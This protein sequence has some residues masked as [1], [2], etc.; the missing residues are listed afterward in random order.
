MMKVEILGC[1]GGP[2]VGAR[3]S[4]YLV[5]DHLLIDA[6]H[7]VSALDQERLDRIDCVI[8]THC[9]FDHILE[10][11]FLPMTRD[12]E[13]T[14]PLLLVGA[15]AVL[16]RV[17]RYIFSPEIWFDLADVSGPFA[18][19]I[20]YRALATGEVFSQGD[21]RCE[22]IPVAHEGDTHGAIIDGAEGGLAYTSDTGPSEGIWRRLADY[23]A[24]KDVLI[25]CSYPNGMEELAL[26]ANHLTPHLVGIEASKP[27]EPDRYRFHA[28]HI[29]PQWRQQTV[30][31]IVELTD[32][33]I[34]PVVNGDV[35]LSWL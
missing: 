3:L 25:D 33:R 6:G 16:D 11:P 20:E 32:A 5:D 7:V 34:A 31:E 21:L 26:R 28:V 35:I 4:S 24:V 10:L 30:R 18:G 14:G 19:M 2:G 12:A 22:L 23:P 15:E 1:D 13:K 17:R 29:K 8:I 27:A 9:H